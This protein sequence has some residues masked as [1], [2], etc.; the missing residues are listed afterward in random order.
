MK[1]ESVEV[2]TIEIESSLDSNSR[3]GTSE[4]VD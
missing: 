4:R 3:S 2:G 1:K